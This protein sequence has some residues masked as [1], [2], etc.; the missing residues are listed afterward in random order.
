MPEID[1]QLGLRLKG[2]IAQGNRCASCRRTSSMMCTQPEGVM[3]LVRQHVQLDG[4]IEL[5]QQPI[6]GW[7]WTMI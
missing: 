4:D 7:R 2:L 6:V 5:V 1:A 3:R